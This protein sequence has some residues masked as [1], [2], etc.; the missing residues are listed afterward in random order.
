MMR[1][2]LRALF[3]HLSSLKWKKSI[4]DA[5][6][7]AFS[8]T[9]I[10]VDRT[11]PDGLKFHFASLILDELDNAGGINKKQLTACLKPF[12]DLLAVR[13]ISDYLF[14]SI[15][16]EVFATILHQ[17]SEEMASRME[18]ADA[19]DESPPGIEFDYVAIGQMLFNIGKK[20]ETISKRRKKL[21]DLVKRFDVAA[22]GGDP[23]YF[24]SPTPEIVLTSRD[25]EE[26]EK[27]LKIM[28]EEVKIERKR[29]KLE[30]KSTKSSVATDPEDVEKDDVDSNNALIGT[31]VKSKKSF[32]KEKKKTDK[33]SGK[34]KRTKLEFSSSGEKERAKEVLLA[35]LRKDGWV[36]EVKAMARR[37]IKERG[38]DNVNLEMLYEEL[39]QPA[40]RLVSEE[41]KKELYLIVR[42]WVAQ[43]CDVE[44]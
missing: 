44:L 12:A 23:Y 34:V 29:M 38:I 14:D 11:F 39:K 9:T 20:P 26:A 43:R 37:M 40:R 30:R 17:K 42:D 6:W 21:Y 16:E 31:V 5:Y 41:A 18:T 22:K 4:R 13:S 33:S 24:E 27:K 7:N 8:N 32:I 19:G 28:D 15:T 25:Y 1:R 2:V 36:T 3:K 10:S 35:R